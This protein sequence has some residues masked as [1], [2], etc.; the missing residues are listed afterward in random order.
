MSPDDQ[1]NLQS[2][3]DLVL[4]V[5]RRFTSTL[6]LNE[7]LSQVLTLTVDAVKAQRGS[8]FVLDRDQKV[9]A[10]ILARWNLPP[11]ES[12]QVV[13]AVLEKGAAGHVLR[14]RRP[15]IIQDTQT[16]ERW[17]LFLKDDP[18]VT[19]SAI[20]VPLVY[21]GELNGILTLQHAQPNRFDEGDLA[22]LLGIGGQAAIAIENARLFTHV[23]QGRARLQA[24]IAGVAEGIII[25][26]ADGTIQ[27]ANPVGAEFMGL[28]D[29]EVRGQ[30]LSAFPA[31]TKLLE[32]FHKLF[33]TGQAQRGEVRDPS[34]RIFDATLVLVPQ[35][36]AVATL[37]N[38]T[39]LK[40]L[41]T[42]KSEF[43]ATVSH[44]L[45]SPLSLIYG[46]ASA[47][48]E[49]SA[50]AGENRACVEA[51]L[52]GVQ[53]MEQMITALLDLTEIEIGIT[54]ARNPVQLS[55]LILETVLALEL[56]AAEKQIELS[57]AVPPSLPL[58]W[59]HSVRLGQ[60]LIN[61]ID[62]AIKYTPA[63]GQVRVSARHE[64]NE[65][66]VRVI[67]TGPG[68]PIA[69]QAGLFGKFYRVGTKETRD[70][71]GHGLG[72]AIVKSVIETHGGRVWVE[73]QIGRGSTFAFS[74]PVAQEEG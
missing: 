44:D 28:T 25:V 37:H 5:T 4:E 6:E 71:E 18:F 1:A 7:L 52:Q 17:H 20:S 47:L 59:G 70:L 43:V 33:L 46:Y 39:H 34:G 35:A 23:L 61:L 9:T 51:I 36:G 24:V 27:Y 60:A 14:T 10:K 54:E 29:V 45:K 2:R 22:V 74:L 55:H 67:D 16:D 66:V 49:S 8:I 21:K 42:L 19:R 12:E 38:V 50:V 68:I 13:E 63:G 15:I 30:P 3:T 53:K 31:A 72:L 58:V 73:S 32:L 64:V 41:D 65:V 69:K 26:D 57:D 11:A 56:K 48:A 62:N 40:E